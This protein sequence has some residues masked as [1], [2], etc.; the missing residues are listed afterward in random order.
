MP[1]PAVAHA[2]LGKLL[3]KSFRPGIIEAHAINN[4]FIIGCAEEPRRFRAQQKLLA[5][6]R[7][8]T[9]IESMARAAGATEAELEVASAHAVAGQEEWMLDC[10]VDLT[11]PRSEDELIQ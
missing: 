8:A 2:P 5:P 11:E 10:I 6:V 3:R 9:A 4:G 1:G 7:T